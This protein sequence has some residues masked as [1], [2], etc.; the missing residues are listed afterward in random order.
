MGKGCLIPRVSSGRAWVRKGVVL[1]PLHHQRQVQMMSKHRDP[2]IVMRY[3]H[4]RQNLDENA[5]NFLG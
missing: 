4:A 1:V 5:V 2:K 3:D